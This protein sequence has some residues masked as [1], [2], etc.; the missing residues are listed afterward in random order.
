ME[1]KE[2][3]RKKK[4][5]VI[6]ILLIV[7][8]A[9]LIYAFTPGQKDKPNTENLPVYDV[10]FLK[11]LFSEVD[12]NDASTAMNMWVSE[13][14]K[15]LNPE[16]KLKPVYIDQIKDIEL[17]SL[18][19]TALICLNS[20]DFLN[21]KTKLDLDGAFVPLINGQLFS[22]FVLLTG[23]DIDNISALKEAK[24]GMELRYDHFIPYMWLDVLLNENNLPRTE[25]FFTSIKESDKESR[26]ILSV[27]FGQLDACIV[28]KNAYDLMIELNPQI[29]KKLKIIDKS[30]GFLS[31]VTCFSKSF[32]NIDHRQKIARAAEKLN[33][34][35]GGKQILTLMKTD[36]IISFK[37]EYL[38]NLKKL[39]KE[40]NKITSEAKK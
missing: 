16:F 27:F 20:V 5:P 26:L 6:I 15:S 10:I 3:N 28:N 40:Y 22:E 38:D 13:L 17:S 1:K 37:K 18:K 4:I 14:E 7:I 34:Y 9:S 36:Q 31:T 21:Y 8:S 2:L 23:E 35:A 29:E 11:N 30:P 32:K 19:N 25:K 39:L 12:L 33:S 24:I